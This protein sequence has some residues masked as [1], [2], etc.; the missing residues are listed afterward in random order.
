MIQLFKSFWTDESGQT[1][2]EYAL[3]LGLIAIVVILVLVLLG[4]Q[5]RNVFSAITQHLNTVP[6]ST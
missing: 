4:G 1:L 5:I 3:L 6:A 2:A